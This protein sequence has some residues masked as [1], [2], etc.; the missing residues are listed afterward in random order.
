ME[1]SGTGGW[2]GLSFDMSLVKDN[3]WYN[4]E[5]KKT[6]NRL[7]HCGQENGRAV[8]RRGCIQVQPSREWLYT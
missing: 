1:G 8:G 6:K 5:Q 4:L 3:H 7:L 2:R